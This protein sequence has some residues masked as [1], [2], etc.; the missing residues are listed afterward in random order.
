MS[1]A[2]RTMLQTHA[3]AT[4]EAAE[5]AARAPTV[6]PAPG[7]V[8]CQ[9]DYTPK[10]NAWSKALV[11]V[12]AEPALAEELRHRGFDRARAFSWRR[13]AELTREVYREALLA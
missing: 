4:R 10:I 13:T 12:L 3:E 8:R 2:V 11:R 5:Q 9:G 7:R 6:V 1:E